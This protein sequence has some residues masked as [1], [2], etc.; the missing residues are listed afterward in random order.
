MFQQCRLAVQ[1]EWIDYNGHMNVGYYSVAFDKATDVLLDQFGLGRDYRDSE[2]ASV[3]IVEAHLTYEN[4][5]HEGQNLI[6]SSQ[7]LDADDKRVHFLHLMHHEQDG[8]LA[9]SNELLGLHVDLGSRR[10]SSFSDHSRALI[11]TMRAEH[12]SL[13][14]PKQAGR[15]MAIRRRD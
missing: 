1:P 9:A 5:V 8:L 2:N 7:V 13:P 6:F 10:A 15:V 4:E 11:E 12:A 14:R 3:F